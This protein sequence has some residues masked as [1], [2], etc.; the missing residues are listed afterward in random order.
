M[1]TELTRIPEL[2]RHQ[3]PT[4]RTSASRSRKHKMQSQTPKRIMDVDENRE[5]TQESSR[6]LH[7]NL[8]AFNPV[9]ILDALAFEPATVFPTFC[10]SA[11]QK[12]PAFLCFHSVTRSAGRRNG[13]L[14]FRQWKLIDDN[15]DGDTD[16]GE[17][18]PFLS[19]KPLNPSDR[20]AANSTSVGAGLSH[21]LASV[22][23][24]LESASPGLG[25]LL[26]LRNSCT[27]LRVRVDCKSAK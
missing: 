21:S 25:P 22:R 3:I 27:H 19:M 6:P 9:Y 14:C 12:R 23:S 5:K 17:S 13:S 10:P 15:G 18:L 1:H 8:T 11:I 20:P 4:K 26:H 16:I 7:R 24:T 2:L